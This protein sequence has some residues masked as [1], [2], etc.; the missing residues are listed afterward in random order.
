[1]SK[2]FLY[3]FVIAA[4]LTLLAGCSTVFDNQNGIFGGKAQTSER[5]VT[6]AI[7]QTET[8]QAQSSIDKLKHISAFAKG[9]VEYSL[10]QDT[11]PT[12]QVTVAKEMNERVEALAGQADF[13]EV[14]GIQTI[15]SGLLSN[16]KDQE[17]AASK[18]LAEK[19]KEI[20]VIQSN[21]QKLVAQKDQ[22]VK[23]A[24][25]VANQDAQAADKA[26]QTLSQM[27]RWFGLGAIW[28]GIKKF[29]ISA[30]W[31]LGIG[32]VLFLVL[33]LL[34]SSNPIASAIFS[35]F[36]QAASVVVKAVS[37]VF[38]KAVSLAGN[39]AT[40]A[41]NDVKG[42]L[43]TLV[44]SIETVKLQSSSSGQP[45]SIETLLNTAELSMTPADKQLIENIKV[46]LGWTKTA[47]VSTVAPLTPT[48][49]SLPV[50]GSI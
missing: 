28:Y 10:N 45:A 36:D 34:A 50:S 12:P 16:Q 35:I 47:S 7:H 48:T 30:A 44:D 18:A 17:V 3:C 37:S 29:V 41:Y 39:V 31:V 49:G 25:L 24:I 42:T 4:C 9:G 13:N 8:A 23:Q 38:P 5:E 32:S 19:D 1:M 27:D 21:D 6:A 26:N 33:R 43:T 46:E 14:K 15:V 40:T 11:N 22:E 2:N 20:A